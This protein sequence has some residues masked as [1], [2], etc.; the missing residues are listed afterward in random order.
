MRNEKN[1]EIAKDTLNVIK[2][3]YY[4]HNG[5]KISIVNPFFSNAKYDDVTV[6]SPNKL[7]SIANDDDDTFAEAF[8]GSTSCSFFLLD[9]DSFEVASSFE[10]GLVMNFANAHTVGGGF[11][12]GS[13]AQEESLCRCST[14]YASISSEKASAM[15]DYNNRINEPAD[16]DFMLLSR[17][18]C[19]FK[20]RFGNYLDEPYNTA[21]ITVA[22]PN[23]NGKASKIQKD[24]LR[25]IIKTRLKLF[26]YACAYHGYKDLVLGAWGCGAFGNNPYDVASC[27]YDLFFNNGFKDYFDNI[28]FAVLGGGEN[29]K[30]FADVFGDEIID[31]EGDEDKNEKISESLYH[32]PICN[33]SVN[34]VSPENIGYTFGVLGDGVPFEAELWEFDGIRTVS[35]YI[36]DI[37]AMPKNFEPNEKTDK[38][39]FF[40]SHCERKSAAI[41]NIGMAI[42]EPCLTDEKQYVDYLEEMGIVKYEG[43][44]RNGGVEFFTDFEGNDI[45]CVHIDLDGIEN[46]KVKINLHFRDFPGYKRKPNIKVFSGKSTK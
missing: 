15:Y 29:Y 32:R 18:V 24:E 38:P 20:D 25:D 12:K 33:H 37:F 6:L 39:I 1:V 27:F 28:A 10:N 26:L 4:I 31:C 22:A 21:V 44:V 34:N 8:R 7:E 45:V 9:A 19:V 16:S 36:P 35:V 13:H 5:E 42:R 2:N 43:R 46:G 17:N 11:L 41:L 3:G 14:L 30:A 40:E 23:V